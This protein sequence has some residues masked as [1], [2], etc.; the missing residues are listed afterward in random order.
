MIIKCPLCNSEK[1]FS[2]RQFEVSTLRQEWISSFKFDPFNDFL[3]KDSNITNHRCGECEL[4]FFS[5]IFTGNSNLYEILAK[6]DWYYEQ[7]KWEFDEAINRLAS[8]KNINSLLEIGCGKGFFLEKV[9][10][11]YQTLGIEINNQ[12]IDICRQKKLN[13]CAKSLEEI[14]TQFNAIV[15]FE[16]LEHIPEPQVFLEKACNL[17]SPQGTLILAMP[18]PSSYLREFDHVLLDMP[19]HHS[20]KWS[21]KAIEYLAKKYNLELVGISYEPLRYVHYQSYINELMLKNNEFMTHKTYIQK[22]KYKLKNFLMSLLTPATTAQ[23]YQIHKNLLS[24]QTQLVEYRK[25]DEI[26]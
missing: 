3:Y 24:G 9:N 21:Q 23:G 12:A 8:N 20:T 6:N 15:S 25:K 1:I 7:N 2:I 10:N 26:T 19:P 18:N 22:F 13:V 14:T 4:E 5:P 17:L 16:V 11:V